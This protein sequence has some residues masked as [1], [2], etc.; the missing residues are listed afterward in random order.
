MG[1]MHTLAYLPELTRV[2]HDIKGLAI[3]ISD[4][5]SSA[6][7]VRFDG[8]TIN[9]ALPQRY[10]QSYPQVLGISSSM[11]FGRVMC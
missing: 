7:S 5:H 3:Q 8:G 9:S 4:L 10:T 6:F 11:T 1:I 2:L